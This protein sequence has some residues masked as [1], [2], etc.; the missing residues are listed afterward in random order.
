MTSGSRRGLWIGLVL[1]A[2]FLY[3]FLRNLDLADLAARLRDTDPAWALV[4]VGFQL[5]VY[6]LKSMRW[7]L[8]L[9]AGGPRGSLR[10]RWDAIT[11]G[12]GANCVLPGRA[13]EAVRAA[14]FTR[15]TGAP[16]GHAVSSLVLER[17]FD[18]LALAALLGVGASA[19]PV[20]DPRLIAAR[21]AGLGL[22][23]VALLA[24]PV[25]GALARSRQA[26]VAQARAWSGWAPESPRELLLGF[27]Q[28]TLE[29][30]SCLPNASAIGRATLASAAHWVASAGVM[31]AS[32][33]AAG[34][35]FGLAGSCVVLGV[36][37]FAVALP[38][39]PG[40]VGAFQWAAS[41][42]AQVMGAGAAEAG[43]FAV[44]AWALSTGTTVALAGASLALRP[45][46]SPESA[47]RAAPPEDAGGEDG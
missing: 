12:F 19:L 4:A 18:I 23:A 10:D 45:S 40:F 25:L 6:L 37:A 15:F 30:F 33:K 8:F 7:S 39:A 17:L 2:G 20:E 22:A 16:L 14:S 5:L 43:A 26:V 1:S 35:S 47:R 28:T 38:Q 29:G 46:A 34:L 27:L 13:G 11:L 36:V 31:W 42:A 32:A 3:L 41:N 24:V 21:K 44:L 9:P